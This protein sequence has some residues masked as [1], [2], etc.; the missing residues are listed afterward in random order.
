MKTLISSSLGTKFLHYLI[1]Q[2]LY[3]NFHFHFWSCVKSF[4]KRVTELNPDLGMDI[5]VKTEPALLKTS[6]AGTDVAELMRY[7]IAVL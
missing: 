2:N 6:S 7:L 1:G 4:D 5:L 3:E